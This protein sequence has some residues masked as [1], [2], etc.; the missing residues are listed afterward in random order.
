MPAMMSR[1]DTDAARYALLRR[2]APALR[3]EAAAHLQPIMMAGSVLERRLAAPAP[4]LPQLRDG[5]SRLTG[6]SRSAVHSCLHLVGWLAPPTSSRQPLGAVVTETTA[7][8][9]TPLALEG[10]SLATELA[11]AP[12]EAPV[13]ASALRLVLPACLLWLTDQAEPGREVVVRAHRPEAG[14]IVLSLA[15]RPSPRPS[16]PDDIPPDLSN[17]S[18]RREPAYRRLDWPEVLA[19]A[20]DEGLG[21]AVTGAGTQARVELSIAL[22]P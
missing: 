8:L 18:A 16:D 11:P 13:D 7:L 1:L 10:F 20:Q 17:A 2:L 14:P 6:F 4:D 22:H 3:H 9:A 19:L 15:L 12:T 21:L 5:V